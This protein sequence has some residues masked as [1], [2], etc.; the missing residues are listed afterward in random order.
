MNLYCLVHNWNNCG[1]INE[2]LERKRLATF[3]I[4]KMPFC[5]YL[6]NMYMLLLSCT[7]LLAQLFSKGSYSW[8]IYSY[9][10]IHSVGFKSYIVLHRIDRL[11]TNFEFILPMKSS[12]L[13]FLPYYRLLT[14]LYPFYPLSL[15]S[16]SLLFTLLYSISSPPLSASP[17]IWN[18]K[19]SF[20][21]SDWLTPW[22][23]RKTTC[24]LSIHSCPE[25]WQRGI[26]IKPLHPYQDN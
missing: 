4:W 11:S 16:P 18:D 3:S 12:Q 22:S 7:T 25:C 9:Y 26:S 15:P 17:S 6:K 23:L 5:L 2:L 20:T 8:Y 19:F 1:N 14:L 21:T 13:R 24:S 10:R